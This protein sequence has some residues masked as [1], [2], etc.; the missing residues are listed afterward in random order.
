MRTP[1]VFQMTTAECGLA[2]LAMVAGSHGVR[3]S[4]GEL[5]E[6]VEVGRDG[7][8]A[9]HLKEA[10]ASLGL[11]MK[12]IRT[13]AGPLPPIVGP[14]IALW[15]GHHFVVVDGR[16]GDH[17]RVLDPAS[18]R[19][20]LTPAEFAEDYQGILL[21]FTADR[22]AAHRSAR[23]TSTLRS[24]QPLVRALRDQARLL[25]A[26]AAVTL[27]AHL[28]TLGAPM[29]VGHVIDLSA[30]AVPGLIGVALPAV[31][32]VVATFAVAT[33][34]SRLAVAL[35]RRLDA[36]LTPAFF[37]QLVGLP[38]AELER[39]GTGDLLSRMDSLALARAALSTQVVTTVLDGLLVVMAT[40]AVLQQSA[41]A[42]AV[43]LA[44]IALQVVPLLLLTRRVHEA[45]MR[46]TI[47]EGAASGFATE[48]LQGITTLKSIG[49]E[50]AAERRFA[51]LSDERR[52]AESRRDLL[53]GRLETALLAVQTA[54]PLAVLLLQYPAVAAGDTSIGTLVTTVGLAA[55]A[56][57]PAAR[58]V[59]GGQA[60]QSAHGH[61]L[62]LADIW[63]IATEPD[64]APVRLDGRIEVRSVGVRFPGSAGA[65]VH[66]V[67]LSIPRGCH[68]A[69]VGPSG[70]GKSTLAKV[71]AGLL[72]PTSGEVLYDGRPGSALGRRSLRRELGV[73]LQDVWLF[74]GTIHENIT[75][76]RP[77]DQASVVE[78]ARLAAVHDEI[79]R[80][81]LGYETR[82]TDGGG[83]LSGGQRQRIALA[84]ALAHSP[85]V[86]VLDE[87]TSNLDVT[88]EA[89]VAANLDGLGVTRI[90]V[91]HR[92]STVRRADVVVVLDAGEVAQV[93][94]YDDLA[95][96][97]G[98]FHD[99]V[100][101]DA[102]AGRT[103]GPRSA[104]VSVVASTR[105]G[106]QP[107]TVVP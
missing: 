4:L 107:V 71:I 10:A 23:T 68:V 35:Q 37:G 84:R 20:R 61:L 50:A 46:T 59:S 39:R 5:R 80:L 54:A 77:L 58:F 73:V 47:W 67:S 34:R 6:L 32:L 1:L 104:H 100:T 31:A 63:G 97:P 11:Q 79:S 95:C 92:L 74:A 43:V 3:V 15:R 8:S 25:V 87:A 51:A 88:T 45:T 53:V 12:A 26:L 62:R 30:G 93:G 103:P 29:L 76:D 48:A 89:E 81:P 91:A 38:H 18:G 70:S 40:L 21:T 83:G 24:L 33:G 14:A 90:A 78:A 85:T 65:A 13:E 56:V 102:M 106:T 7:V 57:G 64:G 60:I 28:V 99:M 86:V 55:A 9:L 42:G 19:H 72:E 101:R 94:S 66:D 52:A 98:L 36:R 75:L 41:T 82:L 49:G 16:A 44:A 105:T 22:A 17:I 2:C 96:R 27:A 69:I